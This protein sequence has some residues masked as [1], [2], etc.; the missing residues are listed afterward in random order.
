MAII[1]PSRNRRLTPSSSATSASKSSSSFFISFLSAL[2][3]TTRCWFHL[4]AAC[5]LA[6]STSI[7]L[8]AAKIRRRLVC[9]R[10][11]LRQD[12]GG[13][14]GPRRVGSAEIHLGQPQGAGKAVLPYGGPSGRRDLRGRFRFAAGKRRRGDR[15]RRPGC[16]SADV[17]TS[18]AGRSSASGRQV[19][20]RQAGAGRGSGS[21]PTFGRRTRSAFPGAL[22]R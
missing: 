8:R 1:W 13:A 18:P 21:S 5:L 3:S 6:S 2:F 12:S 14:S 19:H 17:G 16:G 4:V 9:R 7:R 11:C 15:V 22:R 20:R 10:R